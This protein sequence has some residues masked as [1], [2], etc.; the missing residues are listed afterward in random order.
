M[1]N[2]LILLCIFLT[3]CVNSEYQLLYDLT[4]SNL[5]G[6]DDI[7]IDQDFLQARNYS[8]IKVSIGKSEV[9]VMSLLSVNDEEF[10]WLGRNGLRLKTKYGRVIETY[11]LDHNYEALDKSRFVDY[12]NVTDMSIL[13]KLDSPDAIFNLNMSY[14]RSSVEAVLDNQ[15]TAYKLQEK[16]KSSSSFRWSGINEYWYDAN[17][18]EPLKTIHHI[19]PYVEPLEIEFY[20]KYK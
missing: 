8:F 6:V 5:L 3:S 11:G 18:Y 13:V 1:N 16:F 4:K 9:F 15:N 10:E 12:T 19:H 20:Y 17:S 14:E 7:I 2:R